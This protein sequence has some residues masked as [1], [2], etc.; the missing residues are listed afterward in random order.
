[1]IGQSEP[2]F[3]EL[4]QLVGLDDDHMQNCA[5]LDDARRRLRER[6]WDVLL[7]DGGT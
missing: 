4:R 3:E 2:L 6:A 5:G 7:T 1:M